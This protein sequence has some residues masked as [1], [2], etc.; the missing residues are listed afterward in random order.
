MNKFIAGLS[1]CLALITSDG[2]NA[3][4]SRPDPHRTPGAYTADVTDETIATTI[5][6][7]GWTQQFRPPR[8]YTSNLKRRQLNEWGFENRGMRDYE[9]DHLVPLSLGGSPDDEA[10]LWP[11]PWL[12]ADGWGADRKD[13][14]E[15]ALNRLVCA[16]RLPLATAREAIARD[17]I[18][19]YRHYLGPRE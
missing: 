17:W 4:G 11:E 14:L 5:C 1:V 10:N 3:Q 15:L 2:A 16:G 9:E 18:G 8:Q 13:E 7:R 12:P 6:V 19:A